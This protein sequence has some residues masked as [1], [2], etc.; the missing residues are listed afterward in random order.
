MAKKSINLFANVK[1]AKTRTFVILFGAIIVIG[2]AV[3]ITRNRSAN[4]DPLSK[5]GSQAVAVPTSIQSTPG[6]TV[7]EQ[8]RELQIAENDRRAQDALKKKT[9]AIPTIIG[10]IS[11]NSQTGSDQSLN[12]LESALKDRQ[13]GQGQ[14]QGNGLGANAGFAGTDAFGSANGPGGGVGGPGGGANGM[15]GGQQ[16]LGSNAGANAA[17]NNPFG[18][19]SGLGGNAGLGG[20]GGGKSPQEIAREQ[21]EAK[22]REQRERLDKMREEKEAQKRRE[23]ELKAQQTQEEQERKAYEASVQKMAGQM[24]GYAQGA[25]S[26]WSKYPVQVF[27]QG[28]LATK[29]KSSPADEKSAAGANK[30]EATHGAGN[31]KSKTQ[32]G[33]GGVQKPKTIIKAGTVLFGIMDT[34]V[35]SDE[36]GPILATVV[37]GKYQGSK[38]IGSFQHGGQQEAI[39]VSFTQMSIPKATNSFSVQAVAIDP[40]TARTALASDVDRHYLLRY[41]SLFASAFLTGYANAIQQ[42][43]STTTTSPLTGAT[44]T[45]Y[46]P[47]D[48]RQIFLS[49]LGQVGTQWGQATRTYFN[50]PYTVTVDQG[51]AIGVLF[52]SDIDVSAKD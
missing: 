50:T 21:Q 17:G 5:Q 4:Q 25:Y 3:A 19:A 45:S 51:A 18:N 23:Q 35:N 30:N 43:G 20:L 40:D 11:E 8:Y 7:S 41:G 33:P 29:K 34:A 13:K 14:G 42:Q 1:N 28:D 31:T 6:S 22:I 27:V 39:V 24:K 16:G 26:E 2:I 15:A 10:A 44:T 49:A 38:L 52:L 46:P 32:A 48:N 9:S 37:S 12:S 36:N 47:L